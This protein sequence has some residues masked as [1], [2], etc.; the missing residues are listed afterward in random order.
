MKLLNRLSLIF[1]ET[2]YDTMKYR[3]RQI[4][5]L[6]GIVSAVMYLAYAILSLT[7]RH[8]AGEFTN[9]L[10]IAITALT[11]VLIFLLLRMHKTK[12]RYSKKN[13]ALI[14]KN[15]KKIIRLFVLIT[16][17]VILI[18]GQSFGTAWEVG[19]RIYSL[20]HIIIIVLTFIVSLAR[21][22]YRFFR[23]QKYVNREQNNRKLSIENFICI[24]QK[25]IKYITN[26]QGPDPIEDHDEESIC[27][28][29]DG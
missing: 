26:Y 12:M 13:Y 1:V 14:T 21:L 24:A 5:L 7:I 29:S 25:V 19:L 22:Y 3:Y 2:P 8:N 20:I 11:M 10:I 18:R 16:P 27:D 15:L 4:S 28:K 9:W 17:I 6:F 23:R